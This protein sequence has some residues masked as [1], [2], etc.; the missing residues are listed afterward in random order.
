MRQDHEQFDRESGSKSNLAEADVMPQ[1][2]CL[3][4]LLGKYGTGRVSASTP[5][6]ESA[7]RATKACALAAVSVLW[8]ALF[9]WPTNLCFAADSWTVKSPDGTIS[10]TVSLDDNGQL[11]YTATKGTQTAIEASRIGLSTAAADFDAG[12]LVF[13]SKTDAVIDETYSL[14]FGKKKTYV[15]K[16]NEM[17]LKLAKGAYDL[18]LVARAYDDGVA[19]RFKVSGWSS[20]I[21]SENGTYKLPAN[22][23]GWIEAFRGNYASEAFYDPRSYADLSSST[24]EYVFPALLSTSSGLYMLLAEADMDGTYPGS[25]LKGGT[26]GILHLAWPTTYNDTW[27]EPCT[28]TGPINMTGPVVLPWRL[29][30]IASDL[31]TLVNSTLVDNLTTPSEVTDVSWIKGGLSS[32]DWGSD[33]PETLASGQNLVDYSASMG[34]PFMLVDGGTPGWIGQLVTYA[35][36]KGVGIWTWKH[37][38]DF[39][40]TAFITQTLQDWKNT[41]IIGIKIDFFESDCRKKMKLYIDLALAAAKQQLVVNFHGAR[42]NAGWER[43]FPNVLTSEGVL[44]TEHFGGS[45]WPAYQCALPFTRNVVGPMDYTPVRFHNNSTTTSANQLAL[46]ILYE[47]HVQHIAERPADLQ[48][49]P[50]NAADILK[51]MPAGWDE[52]VLLEGSVREYV[53]MARRKDQTWYVGAI[54]TTARTASIPLAFLGNAKYTATVYKDGDTDKS[55]VKTT[56]TVTPDMTLSIPL[57]SNGGCAIKL[58]YL[59]PLPPTDAGVAPDAASGKGGASG[60]GGA[61][62]GSGAGGSSG[63]SGGSGGGGAAGSTRITAAGGSGGALSGATGGTTSSSAGGSTG[64]PGGSTGGGDGAAGSSAGAG[65]GSPAGAG[66]SD[67]PTAGAGAAGSSTAN[68]RARSSGGCSCSMVANSGGARRAVAWM[69]LLFGAIAFRRSRRR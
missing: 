10:M 26:G 55:I 29:V 18:D 15:N 21:T 51:A 40:S 7:A 13:G 3:D 28:D 1:N 59:S 67:G 58:E 38:D 43:R 14:P 47:S 53:T 44:G 49:L 45:G 32:W 30:I 36:P 5:Q 27:A 63:S 60:A 20:S 65:G 61:G 12:G 56:D 66:G 52:L 54:T 17:T 64:A 50:A 24:N 35:K 4:R 48:A 19:W 2:L 34:W 6:C 25:H 69:M 57:R 11:S 62:G 46:P 23:K 41:G 31:N 8:L 68:N 42:G 37:S 9:G 16:A 33:S 39:S 22:T